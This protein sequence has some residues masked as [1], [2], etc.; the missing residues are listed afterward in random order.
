[1]LVFCGYA[2][3]TPPIIAPALLP[4]AIYVDYSWRSKYNTEYCVVYVCRCTAPLSFPVF[5]TTAVLLLKTYS[6]SHRPP[7]KK[8]KMGDHK[9]SPITT[10]CLK[11]ISRT[12]PDIQG[13]INLVKLNL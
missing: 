10:A 4:A 12:V 6:L 11:P 13:I 9:Y 5:Q 8:R 7:K 1:M 2:M 3:L